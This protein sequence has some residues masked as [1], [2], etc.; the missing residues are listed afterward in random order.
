M[1]SNHRYDVTVRTHQMVLGWIEEQLASGALAVGD[2]LPAERALAEK[3]GLSRTS[4]RDAIRVL[5]AL[6]V[7]RA[8][9]GS[10]PE[11]GTI[12]T[13]EPSQALGSMLRFHVAS[14][15]LPVTD[16]VQTRIMLESWACSHA[17]PESPAL[18]EAARILAEMAQVQPANPEEFLLLDVQFHYALTEAAGN[19]VVSAVMLSLRE[20]IRDYTAGNAAQL[21]NA[22]EVAV[23]LHQEHSELLAA[24]LL[25]ENTKAASLVSAHIEG[26]YA[27][28]RGPRDAGR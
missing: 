18:A 11:A 8:G 5:E 1:W 12:I 16:V 22:P 2:R 9:V 21:T 24:L 4:I 26:F 19:S 27:E 20:A 28:V 3:F 25:G 17:D 23:R 6:G 10:G 14:S 7:A 13:A 15:H